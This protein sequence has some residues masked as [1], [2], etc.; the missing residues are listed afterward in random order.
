MLDQ[1]KLTLKDAFNLIQQNIQAKELDIAEDL[2]LQLQA[3]KP[4]HPKL[5][6][7]RGYI[8]YERGLLHQAQ[9]YF[10][11][12]IKKEP[13]NFAVACNIASLYLNAHQYQKSETLLRELAKQQ[14]DNAKVALALFSSLI[15]R[16][17]DD[18]DEIREK[19]KTLN[20]T[21]EAELFPRFAM[22]ERYKGNYNKAV[23]YYDHAIALLPSSKKKAMQYN[24]FFPLSLAGRFKEA[25]QAYENRWES[26]SIKVQWHHLDLPVWQG[27]NLENKK[28]LVW[29]EQGLGD[30]IKFASL[31]S[32]I[33][34][35]CQLYVTCDP[36]LNGFFERSFNAH[37]LKDA[38]NHPNLAIQGLD[39]D[40]QIP[41]GSL[42]F[43]L[44]IGYQ[45]PIRPKVYFQADAIKIAHIQKKLR[46]KFPGKFLVALAWRAGRETRGS[47][48]FALNKLV[49][50]LKHPKI[51]FINYQSKASDQELLEVQEKLGVH[52]HQIPEL[53]LFNDIEGAG[54]LAKAVDCLVSNA[55]SSVHLA[56]SVG[57]RVLLLLGPHPAWRWSPILEDRSMW[58]TYPKFKI[59]RDDI[60]GDFQ[61][62]IKQA[63]VILKQ[64][65]LEF[66]K[67]NF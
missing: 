24:R 26:P 28:L 39:I 27:E 44:G 41:I 8:A 6:H 11:K 17:V 46:A 48:D 49:E 23:E 5:L 13:D 40:Y 35:K 2:C 9:E 15:G 10:L 21:N 60:H 42:S 58:Y 59:L 51:Q 30:E 50:I 36:R 18:M 14:P 38:R 66:E 67:P 53:D 1:K 55:Q 3:V 65:I 16:Q 54:A 61:Y 29:A 62:P 63:S 43:V 22:E 57:A 12:L 31:L 7:Y 19:A 20:K 32:Y 37:I 45:T 33:T 52:I 25:W 56:G 47:R 4:E 34:K 64:Y